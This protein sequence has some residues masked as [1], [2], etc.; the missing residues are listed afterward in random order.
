MTQPFALPFS[1]LGK[2]NVD[3]AGG[4]GASLGE[5]TQ[6]G[7]PVPPGCVVL[8]SS[9]DQ[10]IKETGIDKKIEAELKKVNPKNIKS[11]DTA[12]ANLRKL[13]KGAKF[14]KDIGDEVMKEFLKLKSPFVAVRSSAT[15]EDSS[16]ASWAGELESYLFVTRQ[17]LLE[18]VKT[19]WSSLF[20]PRAIFYR[21]EKKLHKQR[22]SVAVV[23][24][25]MVNSEIAGIAFTAHP[26][27]KNRN[28]IVIEAGWGQGESVVSGRVT[29]DTY[30]YDKKTS[31]IVEVNVGS[32]RDM[33]IQKTGGGSKTVTIPPAN[34]DKQKL[35]GRQ[36]VEIANICE[37]IEKHYKYP[38]DIEWA[39]EKGK[40]YIVQSRPITTL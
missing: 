27:T 14:P 11:V 31:G 1:R 17:K 19:C 34:Q 3:I 36:I 10:F 16:A 37:R 20:T 21:I 7:I 29:P 8:A 35:T 39:L 26:V 30:V 15:A 28:H 38:Q 13:I 4:K 40:F 6:A 24:Q 23:I 2:K 18:N 5:M 33:I 22:V 9:F 12:S 32:Q 25:K